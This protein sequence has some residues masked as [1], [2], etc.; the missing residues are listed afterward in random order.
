MW[1][2]Y[3]HTSPEGKSY[4]GRTTQNISTRSGTQGQRYRA[5][6]RFWN[7]I[8]RF[9]WDS[10]THKVLAVCE[11]E[12]ESMRLEIKYIAEYNSTNPDNGYNR[13]VGGYPCNKGYT[14]EDRKRLKD[15]GRKKWAAEH[16]DKIKEYRLKYEKSQK[17]RDWANAWNKTERRRKHRTEYMRKYRAEHRDRLREQARIRRER[18]KVMV[19]DNP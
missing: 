4:V 11:N 5:N 17:R 2:I 10:F 16:P 14:N 9:G 7:D 13:S 3:V 6:E 15:E 12:E 8:Q 19:L 18:K 1:S